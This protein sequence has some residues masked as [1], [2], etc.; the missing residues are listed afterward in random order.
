MRREWRKMIEKLKAIKARIRLIRIELATGIKLTEVQRLIVLNK[1]QQYI[2]GGR[3]T[4]KTTAAIFW[5]LMW[6]KEPIRINEEQMKIS[7]NKWLKEGRR[8]IDFPAI[9]DPDARIYNTLKL[10]LYEYQKYARKCKKARIKV[11]Q[12]IK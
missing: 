6:R 8:E 4:G 7:G 3:R 5:T 12:V 9:P 1:E 10:T 11:A 2:V